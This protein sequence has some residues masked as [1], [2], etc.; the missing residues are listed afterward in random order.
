MGKLGK[1]GH[2]LFAV[3]LI[4]VAIKSV[5]LADEASLRIG[6][7]IAISLPGEET[8]TGDFP[9]DR[10]GE[11]HLPEVGSIKLTGMP[12][13]QAS[14]AISQKL[15]TAFRD[16][17][18]LS[19]RVKES[20]LVV[21]V[22][23]QVKQPGTVELP[24]DANVQVAITAAG[25]I[26]AGAQLDGTK[27][28][29]GSKIILFNYKKF[30]DTGD[31]NILPQLEPLDV[32]FVPTSPLTGNVQIDFDAQTLARA[33]DGAD[34][35]KAISVFGEVINPAKFSYK[36]ESTIVDM[37]MRAGGVTR[38]ASVEQIRVIA[39]GKPA[40]FNLQEY[41]D[42][43]N[44]KKLPLLKPGA[45]IFVPIQEEQIRK[46][47][48]TV[49]VMGE[50]A[51]PGAFA[52]QAGATFVD[53]L[54]N[55]GGPTRYADTRQIRILK[56]DG[57]V[58]MFDMNAFTEGKGGNI[59]EV[60]AGDAILV[61][62]K[63]E[64]LEPSWLKIPSSRVVQVIGAVYKPGRYEWSD[65]MTLFDLI[66]QAGGPNEQGDL[67]AIRILKSKDDVFK[68][69]IFNL[70]EFI[71]N[72][73]SARSVPKIHAGNIIIMPEL[74]KDPTDNKSMWLAQS[75]ARSIYIMGAVNSGGRYAF[76]AEMGF[77]DILTAADGPS[78]TA[79]LRHIR[80]S[81]RGG[82]LSEVHS[83][84]F[85]LYMETGDE[86][87]LPRVRNGDVIYV[88]DREQ[89]WTE[90]SVENTVRVIGAVAKPG[91]YKFTDRMSI[92]DL[93]AEA[94]G[95]NE[96]ALQD[97]IIVVNIG[98]EAKASYFDLISFSRTADYSKLPVVRNGDTVYVPDQSQ[99]H[100]NRFM[101]GVRDTSQIVA[102]VA[103]LA[104]L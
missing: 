60:I 101:T 21:A 24:G 8:L 79:D 64:N 12:L 48:H 13:P 14:S 33:G 34:E 104:S 82:K 69:Q 18:R 73:G 84:D 30:L 25:G 19:V 9:I 29:R 3:M 39:D 62:E 68:P 83:F 103:A 89:D 38:Y 57:K 50:V 80:I 102:L 71:K 20:K 78:K 36:P 16:I 47:K 99:S 75:P 54:A 43:G 55:S 74:P 85:E 66:A 95:P 44:V 46:G 94:G 2:S 35:A 67:S 59:P 63:V 98:K 53:I 45:T 51:K 17:G 26:A 1:I 42:S 40:L 32:V 7:I 10:K 96:A 87:L 93:L 70:A 56:G 58:V 65:D 90:Q 41:L 77:L 86:T 52:L 97:R 88:P 4:L 31:A 81:N 15:G 22:G 28:I 11:I 92:L 23:G 27:I 37:L 72:G 76:S 5:A 100:W 49:Y 6:D 61:P 91:R